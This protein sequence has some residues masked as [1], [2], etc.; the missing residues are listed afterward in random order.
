M[1]IRFGEKKVTDNLLRSS[2][3]RGG[4]ATSETRVGWE[5]LGENVDREHP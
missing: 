2:Q 3:Q 5:E 4:G 1:S